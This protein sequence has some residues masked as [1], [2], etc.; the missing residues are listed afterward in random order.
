MALTGILLP[1][2][3]SFLLIPL[4]ASPLQCFSAGASLSA[5]SLG[6][7]FAT[8][9]SSGLLNTNV[10]TL[11]TS[12]AMLDDVIGLVMLQVVTQ[13][14]TGHGTASDYGKTIGRALGASVGL[15]SIVVIICR[16]ILRPFSKP[17]T[18]WLC[19]PD[20]SQLVKSAFG[21][22]YTPLVTHTALLSILVVAGSYAGTSALLAAFIAG[23][24]VRWWGD[25]VIPHTDR[26]GTSNDELKYSQGI[27]P[28]PRTH[29]T[30][31]QVYARFYSLSTQ[32]IL[33]PF[34]F[35]SS[36]TPEHLQDSSLLLF[37][38]LGFHRVLNTNNSNV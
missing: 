20:R 4:G 16:L 10:G 5:T 38:P 13:L 21:G 7:A 35:V 36:I 12:A 37:Q 29:Q 15:V 23:T 17:V 31:L 9:S 2:A 26:D 3:L 28:G 19:S 24:V 6:T 34:F 27:P 14:S 1:I 30:G 18:S 22:I 25:V 32:Q 11:L 33:R 8:L